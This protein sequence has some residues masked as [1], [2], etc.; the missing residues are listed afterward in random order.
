MALLLPAIQSGKEKARQA[1][2]IQNMK[3][4]GLAWTQYTNDFDGWYPFGG[5]RANEHSSNA[6]WISTGHITYDAAGNVSGGGIPTDLDV[7]QGLI[8]PYLESYEIYKCPGDINRL[9]RKFSYSMNA[10]Y[11]A[12]NRDRIGKYLTRVMVMC[13]EQRPDDGC[14]WYENSGAVD[15]RD[16]L[17]YDRHVSC[18]NFLFGDG[19]VKG[20]SFKNAEQVARLQEWCAIPGEEGRW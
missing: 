4:F 9:V 5:A 1:H 15:S 10:A 2:C 16:C 20:I 14:F 6:G 7:R 3:Q 19:H 18:T 11:Q 13:E 12:R 17:S 8:W